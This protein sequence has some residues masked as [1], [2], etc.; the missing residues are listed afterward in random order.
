MRIATC[1]TCW[2]FSSAEG[3]FCRTF[4]IV[5]HLIIWFSYI[6]IHVFI[7]YFLEQE[8]IKITSVPLYIYVLLYCKQFV[9]I[10]TQFS[11]RSLKYT[12][13]WKHIYT[14]CILFLKKACY[15]NNIFNLQ[16]HTNPLRFN[17]WRSNIKITI[18]DLCLD[19]VIV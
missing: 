7:R 19:W 8:S 10:N 11:V 13:T 9:V 17:W 18:Q 1:S 6:Y 14:L 3:L 4:F 12:C 5:V 15:N 16:H 2:A